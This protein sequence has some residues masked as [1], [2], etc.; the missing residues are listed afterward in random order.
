MLLELERKMRTQNLMGLTIS[1][2]MLSWSQLNLYRK[3]A[4]FQKSLETYQLTPIVLKTS[5][6]K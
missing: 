3:A 6:K 5:I 4:T 2:P 1:K